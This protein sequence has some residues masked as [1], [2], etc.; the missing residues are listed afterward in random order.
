M[1]FT[2]DG[3]KSGLVPTQTHCIVPHFPHVEDALLSAIF[4]EWGLT[5]MHNKDSVKPLQPTGEPW[6]WVFLSEQL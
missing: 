5:E 6:E 1:K 2:A 4:G 3:S